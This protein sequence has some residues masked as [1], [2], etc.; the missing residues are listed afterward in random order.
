MCGNK[1]EINSVLVDKSNGKYLKNVKAISWE[2]Q[3]LPAATD[4]VKRKLKKVVKNKQ[5]V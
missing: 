2:L 4:I 3:H 1:T 5:T